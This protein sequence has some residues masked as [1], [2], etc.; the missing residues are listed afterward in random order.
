MKTGLVLSGGGA[1]G[2]YQVGVMK[3]I[4]DLHPKRAANP[5]TIISGTSAGAINALGLASSANNFRL[6]VKKTEKIWMNLDVHQVVKASGPELLA[7]LLRLAASLFN[8][9]I[10]RDRPVALLDNEPL[11]QLL[12]R[13]IRFENIQRRIDEGVLD[14]VSVTGTSYATGNSVTFFQGSPELKSWHRV[15]RLGVP[16][17]LDVRHLLGSAAIPSIFPAEK[18]G[19]EYFGD[20]SVRQLAPLSPALKLGA[21]KIL[22]VGVR[23]H[24]RSKIS[25]RRDH[26]PSVAQTLG[27]IFNSAFLD[28]MESDL[29][30]LVRINE[31]LGIIENESPHHEY[32]DLRPVDLLV[33]RPSLDFDQLASEHIDALPF[34]LRKV[35]GALGAGS[36][37][38][39]GNLA[40]YL[41]FESA[42]CE[43]LIDCGYKDAMAAKDEIIRFFGLDKAP[44]APQASN[45]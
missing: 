37:G 14:A 38:G 32:D 19:R 33:I 42:F 26:S 29:N 5:F 13:V 27:H 12:T 4:A 17:K 15:K 43:E 3:A 40:S 21:D 1:R 28:S 8:S 31:L 44:V 20:G 25:V 18:I 11:R 10:G 2:A 22:V 7:N 45:Q 36:K 16:A 30:H 23:G 9:G 35:L 39:G 24:N 6:G 34:G 41:L